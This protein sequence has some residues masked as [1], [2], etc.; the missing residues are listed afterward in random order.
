MEQACP[1]FLFA[2]P[3]VMLCCSWPRVYH[4]SKF[5]DFSDFSLSLKSFGN[6]WGNSYT[7]CLLLI[8]ALRFTCG[9]RK[10]WW[11][12]PNSRSTIS[13]IVAAII[14]GIFATNSSFRVKAHCGKSLISVFQEFFASINEIFIL[15]WGLGT[16]LSLDKFL[17]LPNFLK[18]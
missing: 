2:I 11:Y 3:P 5:W 18:S 12:L 16:R 8:I 10:I 14:H 1:I 9:E 15:V 4:S 13:M 7:S 17:I 6:S